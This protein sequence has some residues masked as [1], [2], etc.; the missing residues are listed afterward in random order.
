V[1][2]TDGVNSR[3]LLTVYSFHPRF[4]ECA[5]STHEAKLLLFKSYRKFHCYRLC[6]FKTICIR[7]SEQAK[8]LSPMVFNSD[9]LSRVFLVVA[10][11]TL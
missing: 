9:L 10:E 7:N 1:T 2:V 8:R 5:Q 3:L 6:L 4:D 11:D